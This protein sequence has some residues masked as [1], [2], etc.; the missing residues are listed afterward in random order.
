MRM[1][2]AMGDS[3]PRV[4]AT[5]PEGP[6]GADGGRRLPAGPVLSPRRREHRRAILARNGST[7]S[8][9][10]PNISSRGPSATG[11]NARR[12]AED[13][14]EL[15]RAYSWPGNVRQ[16]ENTIRRLTVTRPVGRRS[17]APRSRWSLAPNRRSSRSWAEDPGDKLF[18]LGPPKHLRRYFR[19][20]WRACCRPPRALHPHPEGSG[21]AADRNRALKATGGK[22]S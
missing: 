20:S 11:Q 9:F 5:L 13:A 7:T 2:D 3:A 22:S 12:F 6:D 10:W 8:R 4:M 21:N 16:L 1:L 17:P 14:M 18:V 19:P 15:I